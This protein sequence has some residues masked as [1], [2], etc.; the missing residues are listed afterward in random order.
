MVI[1]HSYV[2]LP[3][4]NGDKPT[5]FGI[6]VT[7]L[8]AKVSIRREEMGEIPH[9]PHSPFDSKQSVGESITPTTMALLVYNSST[10]GLEV[11]YRTS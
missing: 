11:I 9:F 7:P 4:S 2:S 5:N 10:Y 3:E 1:F 8:Q 6:S